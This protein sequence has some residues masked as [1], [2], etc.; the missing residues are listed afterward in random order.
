MSSG[1]AC[2]PS[3]IM[4]RIACFW[5]S[6]SPAVRSVCTNPGATALTVTC[7]EA[8]SRATAR[9]KPIMPALAA[10]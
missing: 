1:S 2:R 9:V 5:L 6:L 4:S 10:A 8:T 7:R 3:G